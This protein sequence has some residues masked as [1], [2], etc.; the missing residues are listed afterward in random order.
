MTG[1]TIDVMRKL[2][3][4]FVIAALLLT[5]CSGEGNQS[6]DAGPLNETSN[7]TMHPDQPSTSGTESKQED[8]RDSVSTEPV[9][10]TLY[11]NRAAIREHDLEMLFNRPL[12]E[13]HPHITVEL[14]EGA[15]ME[16]LVVAGEVPDLIATTH[17]WKPDM[18]K[19]GLGY[20]LRD[21]VNE[22][23]FD[24]DKFVPETIE[25]IQLY[26]E[27]G[28]LYSIPYAMN[29]GMTVYNRE[30]FD[31]FNVPYP[32][33]DMTWED[34]FELAKRVTRV[35]EEG[36]QYVGWNAGV[37]VWT[38]AR[39][40]SL[41][42]EEGRPQLASE[43]FQEIFHMLKDW[44]ST[45]GVVKEDGTYLYGGIGSGFLGTRN[46]A[47]QPFWIAGFT[48]PALALEQSG[49]NFDW[50]FAAFPSFVDQPD[51]G[52]EVEF[53]SLMISPVSE[54]KEEAFKVIETVTSYEA[55]ERMNREH[56]ITVLN[57]PELMEQFGKDI[58]I[59][60]GKNIK[61]IFAKRPAPR[62]KPTIYDN[63]INNI[64]NDAVSKMVWENLDVNTVL[65]EANEKAEQYIQTESK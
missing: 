59:Y 12:R 54:H 5:A 46:V 4:I 52:R 57:D 56:S 34:T 49:N 40:L 31:M 27:N 45:P 2:L 58:S 42:D 30:V 14:I 65:R 28:E 50:D 33:D 29:Y 64:L 26:G 41:L 24:L 6:S 43:P 20:D 22:H 55:Q 8:E 13:T 21:L 19:L 63:E 7:E 18:L 15:L 39:G 36:F 16:D 53:Q 11:S 61:G 35:D 3:W 44:Y 1:R 17:V 60:Q 38:L 48:S 51:V 47:M 62:V 9:T 10:L 25:A 23:Q 32:T 37:T